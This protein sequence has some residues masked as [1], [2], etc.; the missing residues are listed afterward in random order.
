MKDIKDQKNEVVLK[1]FEKY[2]TEIKP[3]KESTRKN[4]M[5]RLHNFNKDIQKPFSKVTQDDVLNHLKRFKPSTRNAVLVT[6][7]TFYNWLYDLEKG[8][9][10]NCV[11]RI[12]P[13]KIEHNDIKYR[14]HV[15]MENEYQKLLDYAPSP[16]HKAMLETLWIFGVR[17][18][19]LLSIDANGISYDGKFTRIEVRGSKT[20]TRQVVHKG[21]ANYLLTYFESYHP[22]RGLSNKPLFV[23]NQRKRFTVHGLEKLL[24]RLC[25]KANLKHI[26]PHDFRHTSISRDRAN[27]V[28]ITHIET[29]HGL[30][31]GSQVMGIYDHNKTKDYEDWLNKKREET[32]PTYETLKKQ[33]NI[34]T[35]RQQKEIDILKNELKK[36]AEIDN[37]IMDSL[38]LIAKEMIQKQGVEAIKEI[39]RKHNVPLAKD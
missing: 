23:G 28:P 9:F 26:T 32:E 7:K 4:I 10:P 6:L 2:K 18:S 12:E 33:H 19:E 37:F 39:F 1:E 31:H 11:R 22:Y 15:I 34:V 20:K 14:E 21:R 38:G 27:G 8:K 17:V 35:E 36:K 24:I 3:V 13:L 16:M 5:N 25:K 30:V 29:K